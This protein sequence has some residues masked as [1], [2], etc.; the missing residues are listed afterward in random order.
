MAGTTAWD[1]S[2]ERVGVLC[3]SAVDARDLRLRLLEEIRRVV[4]FDAHAFLLT[5]PETSVGSLPLADVPCVRELPRL[6]RLKYLTPVNRWTA[7]DASAPVALLHEGTGGDP[8]HSLLWRELLSDYRIGDVASSVFRDRFGCWGFLD[9]W[10]SD[11]APRFGP[12]ESRY[13]ARIAGTVTEALRRCQANTFVARGPHPRRPGPVVLLLDP[14]LHVLGQ[15]P[16]AHEYLRVLVPPDHGRAPIPA[17]AY[18]VA[19]QLL[20]REAGVDRHPPHARMHLSEG[21]WLTLRAARIRSTRPS[22]E[23][24]IAV[25]IEEAPPTE[26]SAVFARA[27]G[28][29]AREAEVL[30]RLTAG[31]G[32]REVA[33]R[34]F[35][36]EY[37]VQDHL[38]AVFAKTAVHSRRA[39]LARALGT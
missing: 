37:T 33:G 30:H 35:L 22:Q 16:Q 21:L 10:R 26:R 11:D 15:T 14:E 13:L 23:S 34:M 32:T 31:G 25:T 24:D 18:N 17:S 36:S 7:L 1:R 39:L 5:D 6:I 38:K 8:S 20:A 19:A 4:G 27:F 12:A 28:L 29:S 9:L 2:R 3:G